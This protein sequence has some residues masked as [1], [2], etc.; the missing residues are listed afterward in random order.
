MD[1]CTYTYTDTSI[2]TFIYVYIM[3]SAIS[4]VP[5]FCEGSR[6]GGPTGLEEV[7]VAMRSKNINIYIHL[8]VHTPKHNQQNTVFF[9][10]RSWREAG[11]GGIGSALFC[12]KCSRPLC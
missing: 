5:Y 9:G 8:H 11:G 10:A 7:V 3:M 2:H 1:I 12:C 6:G 4:N